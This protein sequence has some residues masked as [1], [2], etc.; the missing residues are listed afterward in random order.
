MLFRSTAA[1]ITIT[2]VGQSKLIFQGLPQVLG[3]GD[4][5]LTSP[6]TPDPLAPLDTAT[7]LLQYKPSS[8]QTAQAQFVVSY[9]DA[10]SFGVF[11]LNLL[12]TVPN[13]VVS[14]TLSSNANTVPLVNGDTIPFGLNLVNSTTD[15]TISLTNL[16][17]AS[18]QI[19]Q[20]SVTGAGFQLLGLPLL[21]ATLPSG[22]QLKFVVR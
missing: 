2:Y 18:S 21:P 11:S 15:A 5:T 8:S 22:S 13:V 17:S 1:S 12:G 3:S 19:T 10:T 14:Y 4:I 6:G 20:T 16:G 9:Q 7:F